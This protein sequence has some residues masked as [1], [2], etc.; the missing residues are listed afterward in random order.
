MYGFLGANG[1]GKSTTT[2]LI[3]GLL[4]DHSNVVKVFGQ[5]VCEIYPQVLQ[6]IGSLIDLFWFLKVKIRSLLFTSIKH[7]IPHLL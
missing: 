5:N 3:M 2:R 1:A 6:N 4:H 7:R